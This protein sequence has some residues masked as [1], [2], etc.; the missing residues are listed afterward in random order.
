[1]NE[2]Q[3]IQKLSELIGD[4][5]FDYERMSQSGQRTYDEICGL[6]NKLIGG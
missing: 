6:L 1:M 3:I 5:G 4:L 2:D